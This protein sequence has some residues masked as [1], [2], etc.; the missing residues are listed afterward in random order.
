M[1]ARSC[2]RVSTVPRSLCLPACTK[3]THVVMTGSTTV[4]AT[5]Q[6]ER[7]GRQRWRRHRQSLGFPTSDAA[8]G[9]P[10]LVRRAGDVNPQDGSDARRRC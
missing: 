4:I 10:Y 3:R 7:D 8:A 6:T 1:T 2:T 5:P 9:L